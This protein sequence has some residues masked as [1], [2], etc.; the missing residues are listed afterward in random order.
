M[1]APVRDQVTGVVLAGG[2]SRRMGGVNKALMNY[3]GQPLFLYAVTNLL[4]V[5]RHVV[6]NTS[7]DR[8]AYRRAGFETVGD[9]AF[10]DKGPL[11]GVHAALGCAKTPYVAI[12]ACDQLVLPDRVYPTL[13]ASATELQGAYARSET[14][15]VPTCAVLPVGLLDDV[16]DALVGERL[17]LTA[18]MR[19]H[20]R[21]VSFS[22]VTFGN[23]NAPSDAQDGPMTQ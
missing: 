11:A 1:S 22:D 16:R 12:A 18:F 7:R 9:G 2:Q 4:S 15:T 10:G 21:P 17:S 5:C 20:A 13:R 23:V 3:G 19:E 14:D 6:I 8:D